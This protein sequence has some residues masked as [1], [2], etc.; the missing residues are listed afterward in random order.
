MERSTKL[1]YAVTGM[2]GSVILAELLAI[3]ASIVCI[4]TAEFSYMVLVCMNIIGALVLEEMLKALCRSDIDWYDAYVATFQRP[5][6]PGPLYHLFWA[7]IKRRRLQ[8]G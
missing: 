1:K 2:Y 8:R 3:A 7:V 4:A 6:L 5:P